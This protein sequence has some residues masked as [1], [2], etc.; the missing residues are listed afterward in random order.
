MYIGRMMTNLIRRKQKIAELEQKKLKN[1]Y[2]NCK[3]FYIEAAKQII[4]TFPFD[5]KDRQELKYLKILDPIAI[6]DPD[7]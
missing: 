3:E 1:L 7:I 2:I 5:D 4:K 6:L